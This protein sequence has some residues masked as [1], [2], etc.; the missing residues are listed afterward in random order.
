MREWVAEPV[1]LTPVQ[2]TVWL[3]R[4]KCPPCANKT[5]LNDEML[6]QRDHSDGVEIR[7]TPRRSESARARR[8][9]LAQAEMERPNHGGDATR[10]SQS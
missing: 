4:R 9:S 3:Q 10:R 7:E 1:G 8:G 5:Q 6:W 2:R